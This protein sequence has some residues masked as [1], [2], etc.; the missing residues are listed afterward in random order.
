MKIEFEFDDEHFTEGSIASMGV[1]ALAVVDEDGD[2]YYVSGHFGSPTQGEVVG[3][4]TWLME[5]AKDQL[6]E[7]NNYADE[8]D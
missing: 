6:L 5:D 7:R 1:A 3:Q 4:A 2:V 8:E